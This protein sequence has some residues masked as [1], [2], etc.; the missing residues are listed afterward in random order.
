PA[1]RGQRPLDPA[2]D[3]AVEA[4][5][6]DVGGVGRKGSGLREETLRRRRGLTRTEQRT[7]ESDQRLRE[8]GGR[9]L[10]PRPRPN[11]A[12]IPGGRLA[13]GAARQRAPAHGREDGRESEQSERAQ[14]DP[15]QG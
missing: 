8:R 10:H 12:T 15:S 11:V 4:L 13:D 2:A 14:R 5:A 3:G 6:I 7:E 9:V 1:E